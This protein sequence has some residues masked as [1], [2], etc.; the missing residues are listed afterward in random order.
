MR[1]IIN[2]R[3]ITRVVGSSE[4]HCVFYKQYTVKLERAK[5]PANAG[6][7][8]CSSQVRSSHTQFTCVTCSLPVK[9]GKFTC[10]EAASTSRRIHGHYTG[11]FTCGT[12][13]NLPATSM[14]NC[15][16]LQAKIHATYRQKR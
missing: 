5:L 16:L 9:T 13:A 3:L 6:N 14:Q 1:F 4:L 15:L 7:F 8:T 2:T 10:L 12:D 11:N